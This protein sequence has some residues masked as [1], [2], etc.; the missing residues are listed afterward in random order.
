M[1]PAHLLL[2]LKP[3]IEPECQR[4]TAVGLLHFLSGKLRPLGPGSMPH[5]LSFYV[6]FSS[7]GDLSHSC[8]L[9]LP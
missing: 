7:L 2:G 3:F 9:V 4:E 8:M 6:T 1:P 5:P